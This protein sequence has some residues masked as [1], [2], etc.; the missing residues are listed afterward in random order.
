MSGWKI[1]RH[2]LI[3]Y[4]LKTEWHEVT[5]FLADCRAASSIHC[6]LLLLNFLVTLSLSRSSAWSQIMSINFRAALDLMDDF[7]LCWTWNWKTRRKCFH[8]SPSLS[9]SQ[10]GYKTMSWEI[11]QIR[12]FSTD[13]CLTPSIFFSH[14][15]NIPNPVFWQTDNGSAP[16]SLASS[17]VHPT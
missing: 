14:G 5:P 15:S 17:S 1:L 13:N 2:A 3:C 8:E 11:F 16:V 12:T 4:Q 6:Q 9:F 7:W 10:P